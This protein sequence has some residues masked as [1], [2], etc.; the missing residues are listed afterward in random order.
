MQ[1]HS[2]P[3]LAHSF[4]ITQNALHTGT[5]YNSICQSVWQQHDK[6][7]CGRGEEAGLQT[8]LLTFQEAAIHTQACE[9]ALMKVVGALQSAHE[10]LPLSQNEAYVGTYFGRM[11]FLPGLVWCGFE[12]IPKEQIKVRLRF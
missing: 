8:P 9:E 12:H 6:L 5:I 7:V 11:W 4:D 1:L 2:C 3:T 10:M